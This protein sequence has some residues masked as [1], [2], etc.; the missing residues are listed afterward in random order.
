MTDNVCE[1]CRKSTDMSILFPAFCNKC[2]GK[3]LTREKLLELNHAPHGPNCDK[4]TNGPFSR[5][6]LSIEYPYC[7]SFETVRM[8][9]KRV[10]KE[11][12]QTFLSEVGGM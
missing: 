6:Y 11:R 1:K 3:N 4:C 9:S 12:R 2:V 7:G 10:K 5:C 8:K